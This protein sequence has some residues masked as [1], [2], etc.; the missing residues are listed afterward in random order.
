MDNLVTYFDVSVSLTPRQTVP[1]QQVVAP[2]PTLGQIKA[3]KDYLV[4]IGGD[5]SEGDPQ[6]FF[7]DG[8]Y[9]RVLPIAARR[10]VIGKMHRHEHL[11]ML[12]AGEC[13]I[14]T[15]DG[16][17]RFTGPHVWVSQPGEQRVLTTLTDCVF[18]TTHLNPTNTRDM[19]EVEAYVIVPESQID[20]DV[21]AR[22]A[23]DDFHTR[24]L[25][26]VYA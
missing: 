11:V 12:M 14:S 21:P 15:A 10:V 4:E 7:A 23:G 6:H 17:R 3:L 9:G 26:G 18:M 19:A 16:M 8:M 13:V 1:A 20:Y 24:A 5:T 22:I 2:A 25:Q